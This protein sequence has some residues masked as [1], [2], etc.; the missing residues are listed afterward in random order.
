MI[1]SDYS[2][3]LHLVLRQFVVVSFGGA[4]NM[5]LGAWEGSHQ[6]HVELCG[7]PFNPGMEQLQIFKRCSMGL[8]SVK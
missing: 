2:T 3:F 4:L 7:P 1:D 8:L 6:R 5:S